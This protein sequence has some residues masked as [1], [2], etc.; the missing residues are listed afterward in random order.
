VFLLSPQIAR[1]DEGLQ[2]TLG[3]AT[4][5]YSAGTKEVTPSFVLLDVDRYKVWGTHIAAHMMYA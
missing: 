2:I 5:A 4:G 3:S 1:T